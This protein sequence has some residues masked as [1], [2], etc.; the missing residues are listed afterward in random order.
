[1]P[2]KHMQFMEPVALRMVLGFA[3][4]VLFCLILV[5]KGMHRRLPVFV[6]YAVAVLLMDVL[7]HAVRWKFGFTSPVYFSVYWC[8]QVVLITVRAG[9]VA[10]L[11]LYILGS[12]RGLWRLCRDILFLLAVILVVL[13]CLVA[14]H[15]IN[16]LPF[17]A[18]TLE[19]GLEFAIAGSLLTAFLFFR[20]Y[21]IPVEKFVGRIA[22]GLCIY[23]LVQVANN[24]YFT[25]SLVGELPVQEIRYFSFAIMQLV[26]LSAMWNP[27]PA[28]RAAPALLG[29]EQYDAV[30]FGLIGRLRELN[31]R[32][33]EM[34][35]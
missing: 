13:A 19:R 28:K 26:W 24:I 15:E 14:R 12:Y 32:L 30:S 10:Q 11:C 29:A 31:A 20:F 16:Y 23:S 18:L 25:S 8:A 22:V 33:E 2:G 3:V 4:E 21:G 1:M 9:L 5:Q 27:I 7:R 17:F 35:R 34:L 6:A